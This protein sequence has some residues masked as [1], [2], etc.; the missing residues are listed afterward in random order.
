[1]HMEIEKD[2]TSRRLSLSPF[3]TARP[4]GSP[5]PQQ[6]LIHNRNWQETDYLALT[7]AFLWIKVCFP[8]R[9]SCN[10]CD[11]KLVM[12]NSCNQNIWSE[13]C[14]ALKLS[15]RSFYN[16]SFHSLQKNIKVFVCGNWYS[17][18]W[19]A[20]YKMFMKF[21]KYDWCFF[22]PRATSRATGQV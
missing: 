19:L 13:H 16:E 12:W 1:M 22:S 18:L 8:L 10:S 5:H 20:L 11:Y 17:L 6:H 3:V 21:V 9:V 7:L 14:P 4:Q 2:C 15:H